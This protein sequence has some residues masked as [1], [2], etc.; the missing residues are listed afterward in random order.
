MK[1]YPHAG[2]IFKAIDWIDSTPSGLVR[3]GFAYVNRF[4]RML[5]MLIPLRGLETVCE[6]RMIFLFNPASVVA[7]VT[8]TR[9]CA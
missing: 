3:L 9:K 4:H 5:F 8:N 2:L 7:G 6:S 1:K